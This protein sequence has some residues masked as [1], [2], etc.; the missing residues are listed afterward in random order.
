[1]NENL[2]PYRLLRPF[3]F[4]LEPE[5]AHLAAL[6]GRFRAAMAAAG[7]APITFLGVISEVSGAIFT[8]KY[9]V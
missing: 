5:R 3:L 8:P 1:M 4:Q 2:D 6:A 9:K 7:T